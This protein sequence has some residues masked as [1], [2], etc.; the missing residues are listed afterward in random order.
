[1]LNTTKTLK[2]YC[3]ANSNVFFDKKKIMKKNLFINMIDFL[4]QIEILLLN[5]WKLLKFQ[6][7]LVIFVQNSRFF[8]QNFP[9]SR[10]FFFPKLSKSRIPSKVATL[11]SFLSFQMYHQSS[12]PLPLL[13]LISPRSYY[14][15]LNDLQK[16]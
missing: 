7:F 6:V 2:R 3:K 10:F 4:S 15:L 13:F 9:N 8:F 1:M 5:M 16:K 12:V 11:L 14:L